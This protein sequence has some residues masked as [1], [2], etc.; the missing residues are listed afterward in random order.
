MAVKTPDGKNSTDPLLPGSEKTLSALRETFLLSGSTV[1]PDDFDRL[2]SSLLIQSP[3]PDMMLRNLLRFVEAGVSRASLFNDLIRFRPLAE[4]A[5]TVFAHSQYF[6]DILVRDP[7]LFRWLTTT[8]VLESDAPPASF[9]E[10]EVRRI[11]DTFTNPARRLNAIRRLYRREVLRIGA[12][13]ILGKT[14]LSVTTMELSNLA[15]GIIDAADSAAR[16]ELGS[17]YGDGP[18]TPFCVIGL[19]KLGGQELNYSSDVDVMFLYGEEGTFRGADGNNHTFLEYFVKRSERIVQILTESTSEGHLYRVDTRLRPEGGAGPL[20]RS[21]QSYLVY[22]ESRGDLWERQMLIKARPVAGDKQLGMEFIRQIMPFVYPR[23]HFSHP[24]E[25]VGRIKARIEAEIATAD[26]IKLRPGGIRDI[27]FAVQTLQLLHGGKEKEIRHVNTLAAISR[28]E[29]KGHFSNEEA[30]DLTRAYVLY[31]TLEHRLQILLNTQ[32]HRI[33]SD[34]RE[35]AT[36]ARRLGFSN[37]KELG[38]LLHGHFA[39]VR[40]IFDGVLSARENRNVA[41]ID[42]LLDA[43]SGDPES[44]VGQFRFT[45]PRKAVRN[46]RSLLTGSGLSQSRRLDGRSTDAFRSVAG[47]LLTE[48]AA[49]PVPDMTLSGLALLGGAQSFPEQFYHQ[50]QNSAFRNM[51]LRVCSLS[52]YL[53]KG[54]LRYPELLDEIASGLKRPKGGS[55]PGPGPVVEFRNREEVRTG[56]LNILGIISFDEMTDQL[57]AVAD[58]VAAT[59]AKGHLENTRSRGPR[60]AIFAL[61]KYGTR[62]LGFGGDL[63]LIFLTDASEQ[64]AKAKAEVRSQEFVKGMT[65]VSH[66]GVLYDVDARLRPEG[67]SAP[68]V[69]EVTAYVRYLAARASLWERQ[70]LTRLRMV[71]GD[72]DLG[73]RVQDAVVRFVYEAPLPADWVSSIV[74]MRRAMEVRSRTSRADF[75]D[76]KVGPGG[77]ADIEFLAQ[78]LQLWRGRTDHECRTAM[79]TVGILGLRRWEP[80]PGETASWLIGTYRFYR[81]V[82]KLIRLTLE[83]KST[84]LPPDDKLEILARC[85][86]M[87][88]GKELAA[89]ISGS[90]KQVRQ[91]FLEITDRLASAG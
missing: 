62:E 36:L 87:A 84:I 70:S 12:R 35:Q 45:D 55:E 73:R 64:R 79:P 43:G 26:N 83:E 28:L 56:I 48:I 50:L 44:L 29:K 14:D 46:L 53:V 22:Y 38:G 34:P 15:D 10:S 91:H 81:E 80:V 76:L 85:L 32:T 42:L 17:Q 63:D 30:A 13:D 25:A 61:G 1:P 19:G 89:K 68:L 3:D 24:A 74:S 23:T 8:G 11:H 60:L 7:E 51:V 67:K 21:L 47:V 66:E 52:P 6:S 82:E 9:F 40:K 78:M 72:A 37:G 5:A 71:W 2:L 16:E 77:M 75:L 41:G 39:R 31:R 4:L 58:G 88:A 69:T 65:Q 20:A 49:T 18:P 33:P 57:S 54:L 59:V 90:M 86:G 27:E